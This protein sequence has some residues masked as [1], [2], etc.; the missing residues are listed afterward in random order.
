ML[1]PASEFWSFGVIVPTVSYT[2]QFG[3]QSSLFSPSKFSPQGAN[4]DLPK[5]LS[6]I[7]KW[8]VTNS[9]YHPWSLIRLKLSTAWII[10]ISLRMKFIRLLTNVRFNSLSW[11]N[12]W[13]WYTRT[14]LDSFFFFADFLLHFDMACGGSKL[15][16]DELLILRCDLFKYLISEWDW[17]FVFFFFC[18]FLLFLPNFLPVCVNSGN[19][20]TLVFD[21]HTEHSWGRHVPSGIC[22][23]VLLLFFSIHFRLSCDFLQFDLLFL[24]PELL[25]SVK[26]F[27][28]QIICLTN[29]RNAMLNWTHCL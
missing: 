11:W 6:P 7:Q 21:V 26:I 18:F 12:C 20:F 19:Y 17:S 4:L 23:V 9:S 10:T 28:L 5:L 8:S 1:S 16:L 15:H 24:Q 13:C 2:H 3:P 25:G 14:L 22:I 27:I 29:F